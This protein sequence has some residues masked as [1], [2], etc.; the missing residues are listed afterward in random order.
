MFPPPYGRGEHEKLSKTDT[1]PQ[2]LRQGTGLPPAR[3]CPDHREEDKK[4]VQKGGLF[5]MEGEAA[6]K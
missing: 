2:I 1:P 3:F 4:P 5:V 6:E